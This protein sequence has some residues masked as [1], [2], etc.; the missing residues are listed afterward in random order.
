[1]ILEYCPSLNLLN[2]ISTL[3]EQVRNSTTHNINSV[4]L[5]FDSQ[6]IQYIF[7]NSLLFIILLV[8]KWQ[9]FACLNTLGAT[10]VKLIY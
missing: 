6:H 9:L 2:D 10:N 3:H 5:S 7:T 8:S 4:K 1:M